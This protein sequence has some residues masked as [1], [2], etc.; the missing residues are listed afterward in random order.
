L[1]TRYR[2]TLSGVRP[3]AREEKASAA[4]CPSRASPPVV[5]RKAKRLCSAVASLIHTK[6]E[7]EE[8]EEA[9]E[10]CRGSRGGREQQRGGLGRCGGG[11][12]RGVIV[13]PDLIMMNNLN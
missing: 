2:L 1:A 7:E 4:T 12:L 11:L 6:E 3:Q 13:P 9:M 5:A 10:G 8:E